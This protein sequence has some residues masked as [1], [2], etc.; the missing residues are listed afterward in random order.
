MKIFISTTSFG[1][2]SDEPLEL[3]RAEKEIEIVRNPYGRK[4]TEEETRLLAK[5]CV[6]IIAGVEPYTQSTLEQLS[7]LRVISRCG[8][9]LDGI[10]LDAAKRQGITITSTPYGPTQAVAELTVGFILNLIRSLSSATNDVREG[11]WKKHMGLLMSECTVGIIGL[12]RIGKRIALLLKAF[13]AKIIACDKAP[14]RDWALEHDV[15]F[16]DIDDVLRRADVLCLHLAYEKA[17]HHLIGAKEL[18]MMRRGSYLV[19]TSRGGLVDEQALA[20]A[21]EKKQLAGAALD[22]FEREPYTGPLQK[23]STVLLTPHI[24]SYARA[25]R[26]AMERQSTE[27]LFTALRASN[28]LPPQKE[29]TGVDR[30]KAAAQ[31]L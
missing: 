4:C 7:E 22:V 5:G 14:D 17:L 23:I 27:N 24:G 18:A 2:Y 1:E 12:G 25:A 30:Y 16:M 31:P 10:D 20:E 19:N 26:I 28:I 6:G 15:L 8:G 29:K 21:L 13:D 9:G 11:R 3:L